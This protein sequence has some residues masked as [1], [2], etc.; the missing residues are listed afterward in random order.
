MAG[1]AEN[2]PDT[3]EIVAEIVPDMVVV[4]EDMEEIVVRIGESG[5]SSVSFFLSPF[6]S[7]VAHGR[8]LGG[9]R[10]GA[11]GD[12]YGGARGIFSIPF[13]SLRFASSLSTLSGLFLSLLYSS[14]LF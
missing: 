5:S 13:L 10:Y 4:A 2:A 9:D 3:A 6:L 14:L 7:S 12:R 1:T 11:G 8:D